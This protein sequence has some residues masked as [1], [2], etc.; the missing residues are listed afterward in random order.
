MKKIVTVILLIILIIPICVNAYEI[1]TENG[2]YEYSS[3]IPES[4][5][6]YSHTICNG[7]K[8]KSEN[9]IF[10]EETNSIDI[11]GITEQSNCKFY[12]NKNGEEIIN[13]YEVTIKVKTDTETEETKKV[14]N[15]EDAIF[16]ITPKEGYVNPKVTCTNNQNGSINGN[17]LTV[18]NVTN[19]TTCT[20]EYEALTYTVNATVLNGT[21]EG[22]TSKIVN[23]N[24]NTTFTLNPTNGYGNPEVSCTNS[25]SANMND[26]ILTVSNITNNTTCT[27]TFKQLT[28]AEYIIAKATEGNSEGLITIDQPETEQTPAQTEYRYSGSND[29]V[30]NYVTFNNETWRIIGVFPTDDGTGKFKNRIKIVR[31]E[32]V[33]E[34][35]WDG[36]YSFNYYNQWGSSGSYEGADLMM[37]LN[38]GYEN[39]TVNNSLYW[40]RGSGS[41]CYYTFDGNPGSC[42]FTT[43]GLMEE[44]KGM[45][46]DALWYT[47]S[48]NNNITTSDAYVAERANTTTQF[49]DSVTRTTNWVGKVGLLYASDYGY[50]SSEC[51]E[52]VLLA[53]DNE[54]DYRQSKC[55]NT[56]W[57]YNNTNYFLLT[58]SIYGRMYLSP[59]GSDGYIGKM[60]LTYSLLNI[61]PSIYLS[62]NVIITGGNGTKSNPYILSQ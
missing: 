45:I 6:S 32:S 23:Y 30:K 11:K 57:L 37:V 15:G 21:I 2:E 51:Y 31:E 44:T 13:T 35:V 7:T 56:N 1:E 19:D 49:S 10:N 20:I 22:E 34:Y 60:T 16:T 52:D 24:G 38:P 28:A 12:F 47:S 39:N 36:D 59:V 62:T 54:K 55:T 48:I 25:Q 53:D 26:N 50:A 14:N 41:L 43:T 33:G 29:V 18:S 46:D 5:Y 27:V 17:T 4:G 9:A 3:K 8:L 61:R 40:N 42:D 58:S